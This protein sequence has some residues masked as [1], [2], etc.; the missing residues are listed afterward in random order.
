MRTTPLAQESAADDG[1]AE[2]IP[3]NADDA[4]S[5]AMPADRAD[6]ITIQ[7]TE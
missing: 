3:L 7:T 2:P 6:A 4:D 5:E 1:E